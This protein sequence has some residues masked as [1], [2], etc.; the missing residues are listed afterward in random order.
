MGK[1]KN[2]DHN[3]VRY[4]QGKIRELNKKIRHLESEVKALKKYQYPPQ[5]EEVSDDTEET[6]SEIT[7]K[8]MCNG[9]EGCGKG[10]FIEMHILDKVYG[11][12]NVCQRRKRLK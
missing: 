6:F 2:K 8:I 1:T 7:S 3:E 9:E 10:Y 5:D 4:L 12:C 11:T